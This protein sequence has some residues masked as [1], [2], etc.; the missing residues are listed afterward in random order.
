MGSWR[1]QVVRSDVYERLPDPADAGRLPKPLDVALGYPWSSDQL[2]RLAHTLSKE[3]I[4]HLGRA[5]RLLPSASA[6]ASGRFSRPATLRD[7]DHLVE[8]VMQDEAG[9]V[10]LLRTLHARGLSIDSIYVDLL[11]PAARRLGDLWYQDHCDCAELTL[12]LCRLQAGLRSLNNCFYTEFIKSSNGR[13][14]LLAALPGEQHLFGVMMAAEYFFRAGWRVR[15]EFPDSIDALAALADSER[16]DA[17]HLSLSCSL[18]R[19]HRLDAVGEA[20]RAVRQSSLNPAAQ[21]VLSG[22]VFVEQP[23]LAIQMG[24]DFAAADVR[25]EVFRVEG[26]QGA[27]LT[28][29]FKA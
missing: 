4:P 7:L 14:I 19:T 28:G 22:R 17:I 24:A 11:A 18:T 5:Q 21:V 12:G 1:P 29:R 23:D 13:Q 10:S 8:R 26:R 6:A 9:V 3:V 16:F 20:V 25:Q 15:S 27:W 2:S